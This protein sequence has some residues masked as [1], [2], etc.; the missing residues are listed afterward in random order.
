MLPAQHV[1]SQY[2]QLSS[3]QQS[4]AQHSMECVTCSRI[5][6]SKINQQNRVQLSDTIQKMQN[7]QESSGD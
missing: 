2:D 6:T 7:M 1:I 5:N 4:T 3:A